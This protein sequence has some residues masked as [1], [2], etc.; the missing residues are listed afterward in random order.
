MRWRRKLFRIIIAGGLYLFGGMRGSTTDAME[1]KALS[2][3]YCRGAISFWG[4]ANCG[5]C[6]RYC[7][8]YVLRASGGAFF[9][10][11]HDTLSQKV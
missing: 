8:V 10:L 1:V 4:D 9:L 11:G 2:D 6:Y 3:H 7:P 5:G